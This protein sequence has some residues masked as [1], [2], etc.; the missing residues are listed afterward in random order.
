MKMLT[1][2]IGGMKNFV[3]NISS[4]EGAEFPSL[5]S[6]KNEQLGDISFDADRFMDIIKKTLGEGEEQES[7]DDSEEE[8]EE[9]F[10][11]GSG[12]EVPSSLSWREN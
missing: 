10:G 8:P 12:D 4:Y 7:D 2:L 11:M 5:P 9:F 1:E 6:G 3:G